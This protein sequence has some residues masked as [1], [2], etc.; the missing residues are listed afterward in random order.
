MLALRPHLSPDLDQVK[1]V[2]VANWLANRSVAK[3]GKKPL[4]SC[5][6]SYRFGVL[7]RSH[8]PSKLN[9]RVDV[10]DGPQILIIQTEL[11]AKSPLKGGKPC[12]VL[13]RVEC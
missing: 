10:V 4:G 9:L 12:G 11:L 8:Q 3:L 6:L 5:F 13:S 2:V 1:R 7:T